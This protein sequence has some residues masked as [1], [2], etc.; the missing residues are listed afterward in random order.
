MSLEINHLHARAGAFSLTD[1]SLTIPTGRCA[2]LMGPSGSGKTTLMEALCGLRTVDGG[3]IQL[4]GVDITRL[5]PG[6]R[7]IGLVPQ[8]TV[9][10]PHLT[11]RE[12]LAF[13]PRLHAWE[14]PRIDERV[15]SLAEALGISALLDRKPKGLSGGEGKRVA[16]GRAIAARPRLLCLDEALTGL[17]RETHENILLLVRDLVKGEELT[18]LYITHR[19]EEVNE[20]G[21]L[22]YRLVDGKLALLSPRSTNA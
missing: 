13:G 12:H 20:L 3:S 11:V 10:F 15:K 5:R 1:V 19:E 14:R 2:V 8:D 4:G 9:L 7:G 16:L 18:T 21:D 6:A 22:V 17:D